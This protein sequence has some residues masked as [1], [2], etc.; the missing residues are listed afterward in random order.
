MIAYYY[1]NVLYYDQPLVKI[2]VLEFKHL[3]PSGTEKRKRTRKVCKIHKKDVFQHSGATP[4]FV[5]APKSWF[6]ANV[7]DCYL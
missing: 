1:H 5:Q 4:K 3:F 2:I 6:M 7:Y